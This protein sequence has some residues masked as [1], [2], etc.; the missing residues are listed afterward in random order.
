MINRSTLWNSR[1][2]KKLNNKS[3][4]IMNL[5]NHANHTSVLS[6]FVSVYVVVHYC[7]SGKSV[8][9]ENLNLVSYLVFG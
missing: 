2:R 6:I 7:D 3:R 4:K 8:I 9:D 5:V 1:M